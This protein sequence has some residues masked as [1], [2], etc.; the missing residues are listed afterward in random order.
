MSAPE[1]RVAPR[2]HPDHPGWYDATLAKPRGYNRDVIGQMLA[3]IDRPGVVRLRMFPRELHE[4][5]YGAVHGGMILGL[6]DVAGFAAAA[7][8]N[9]QDFT[10]AVT[11]EVSNHFVGAGRLDLPLDAPTEIV[12]ET[13]KLIFVRGTVEQEDNVIA[14]W[15]SILRKITPR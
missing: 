8:L 2:E 5:Q 7:V 12:R 13:G 14:S 3:R 6:I 11:L 4:N 9:G 15:S 1:E 10:G